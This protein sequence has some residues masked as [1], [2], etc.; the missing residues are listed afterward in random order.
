[1]HRY[2]SPEL[3]S[4]INAD[5][6]GQRGGVNVYKYALDNALSY[7]DPLGLV[8]QVVSSDAEE[9]KV[10]QR[11]YREL[12]TTK[13]GIAM[14]DQLEKSQEVYKILPADRDAYYCSPGITDPKCHGEERAIFLDPNHNL[15]LPTS[16][17][18]QEAAKAVILGHEI[19]HAIGD[20]DVGPERMDNVNKNENPVRRGL[21]L[22]D[23]TS[24]EVPGPRLIWVPS[25][26]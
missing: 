22:P 5:P 12:T 11:A 6:I 14:C 19:G 13:R 9:A 4:Y 1:L 16:Q 18:M 3:A 2:Y 21:G 20:E 7:I 25:T 8:V 23:R 26:K 10:L 15:E 24:Y 17:G